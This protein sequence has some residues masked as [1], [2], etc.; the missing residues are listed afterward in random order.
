MAKLARRQAP[1]MFPELFDWL[2]S[3]WTALLPF[4]SA[5]T[6]RVEDY[7]RE[8]R[9]VI[10]A[11]LPGLDPEKDIEVTVD[12]GTLSR[13]G[14][15]GCGDRASQGQLR[16]PVCVAVPRVGVGGRAVERHRRRRDPGARASGGQV[17]RP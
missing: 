15:L 6:L 9:Y 10:R 2:D 16:V 17:V 8:G 4:S 5:Q 3:P 1:A 11:E 7:T 12:D 13:T 14:G